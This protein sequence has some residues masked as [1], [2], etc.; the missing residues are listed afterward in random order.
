MQ[1]IL[2]LDNDV[3]FRVSSTNWQPA[4]RGAELANIINEA[5]LRAVRSGTQVIVTQSR[6]GG[7]Y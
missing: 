6:S 7:E 3:D 4:H 1:K 2:K 5:A